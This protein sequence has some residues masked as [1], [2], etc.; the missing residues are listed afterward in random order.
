MLI[1]PRQRE[2]TQ[3]KMAALVSGAN[4]QLAYNRHKGSVPV[5]RDVDTVTLDSCAR[6]SWTTFA[7]PR[8]ARVP[9]LAHRMAADETVKD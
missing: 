4:A 1:S 8:A 6:D 5:R 2:A 3:E 7:S 9:S